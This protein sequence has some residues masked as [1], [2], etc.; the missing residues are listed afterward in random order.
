MV[1]RAEVAIMCLAVVFATAPKHD[2]AQLTANERALRVGDAPSDPGPLASDLSAGMHPAEID[3]ALRRV[4]D[5]Q[6]ARLGE[7]PSQDWTFATL[8]IG[9][10]SAAATLRQPSYQQQV[11]QVAEHYHWML[12]PRKTHADDQ[13]IGQAY[14]WLVRESGDLDHLKPMQTQFDQLMTIPDDQTK[15]VWWWCDALF[16]APPVWAG[17][18]AQTHNVKYLNYMDREWKITS[19]V[20]WD[21][22]EQL[23]F[24]DKAYLDQR[25]KNGNKVFWSRGNGWVMGGLVRILEQLPPRDPRRPFYVDKLRRMADS[26]IKLQDSDGLWRPGLLDEKDYPLP[27]TSGSSFFVYALA[28][29]LNH[30]VLDARRTRPAVERGWAGLIAHVYKD[31][32]L[33]CVQPVGEK[34]GD[35]AESA[36]SVFGVG[37][38]LLAG[39]EVHRLAT[40]TSK[41]VV[42]G[43]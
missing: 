21:P 35:Y 11:E 34:P 12:G 33:G 22:K 40:S 6:A 19:A 9:M 16:M 14:L 18:A 17:L 32:R 39:S 3:A 29:G 37:A 31:G 10:L 13:A 23:F 8:Y 7:L 15:P 28:W 30:H 5:W 27:E 25:E 36:S 24:R 2:Y 4:A 42:S 43:R 1:R 38:F 26:V 41:R 20:L